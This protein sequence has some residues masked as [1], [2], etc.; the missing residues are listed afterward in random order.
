MAGC[1]VLT[2]QNELDGAFAR[3]TTNDFYQVLN[4]ANKVGSYF[5]GYLAKWNWMNIFAHADYTYN[6]LL[7]VSA[8]MSVDGSSANGKYT[9]RFRVYPSAGLTWMAKN[10]SFLIDKD[11]VNR[12][13]L[14]AEYSVTGNSRF[15]SNYGRN[16][17]SSL[18]YM[19]VS[20]IVR[21]QIPNTHLKPEV[22]TQM[23]LSLDAAFLRNRIS[24]GVDYYRGR[25]KDVIMNVNT[26]A[27]YGTSGYYT[28]CAKS[29]TKG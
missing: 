3:N 28:N 17:Y 21:T 6:N 19:A 15:S 12:L 27:V 29:T 22:T 25:S 16:Y 1:Q 11:W 20:G 2:T 24:L 10:M 9:N 8:N 7:N 18:P 5:D 13:D 14:R 4:S 26:S 23:N